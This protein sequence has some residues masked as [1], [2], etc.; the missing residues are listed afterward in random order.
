MAIVSAI[1]I[2]IEATKGT[3]CSQQRW[4]GGEQGGGREG[5]I[6][7]RQ[8]VMYFSFNLIHLC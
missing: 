6:S 5:L 4:R 7:I 2:D 3:R 8:R 1:A